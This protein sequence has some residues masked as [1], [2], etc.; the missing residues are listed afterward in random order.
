MRMANKQ[1][2]APA[3]RSDVNARRPTAYRS[4]GLRDF[5]TQSDPARRYA[6]GRRQ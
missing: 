5:A 4:A 6:A 2:E 3:S 1:Q